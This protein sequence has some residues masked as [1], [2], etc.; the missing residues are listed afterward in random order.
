MEKILL[1]TAD[2]RYRAMEKVFE[3]A[4]EKGWVVVVAQ[5]P[6][7]SEIR[8]DY[9]GYLSGRFYAVGSLERF[10]ETWEELDAKLIQPIDNA[11][12]MV[13]LE[14]WVLEETDQPLSYWLEEEGLTLREI[15]DMAKLPYVEA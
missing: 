3:L 2:E 12:I 5:R 11:E 13:R 10:G 4:N 14:Q 6:I 1:N 7:P 8:V 9:Y 15:A